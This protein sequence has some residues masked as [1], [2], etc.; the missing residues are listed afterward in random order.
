MAVNK[1][2]HRKTTHWLR[3]NVR[4]FRCLGRYMS[5]KLAALLLLSTLSINSVYAVDACT[6]HGYCSPQGT[7]H[8]KV[9]PV[10][11]EKNRKYCLGA[12]FTVMFSLKA[13]GIPYN[14]SVSDG[15]EPLRKSLEVSFERWRFGA[16]D[17]VSEATERVQMESDCSI[18]NK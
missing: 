7:I 12:N 11:S 5:M 2:S 9:S 14:I 8:I 15:P 3:Q 4:V 6:E 18:Q 17:P 16:I 10:I 13:G 1:P